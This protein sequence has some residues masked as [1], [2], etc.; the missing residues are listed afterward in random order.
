MFHK[1]S[2]SILLVALILLTLSCF[3]QELDAEGCKD[4]PLITRMPGSK[5]NSCDNKEFEEASFPLAPD[6]D[7]NSRVEKV[8]GEYHYWDY[9]TREGMSEIQ[10]FRNIEAALKRAGFSFDFEESPTTITAHKGKT[11]YLLESKGTFY[12]QTTVT[13]KQMEQEVTADADALSN[14]IMKTGHVAVYGVNFDT[15]KAT[16]LPTSEPVLS[17]I[18]KLLQ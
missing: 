7:G 9:G 18:L 17:E 8:V 12:Y 10:I 14:A 6:A 15:G 2:I 1:S 4:S 5:I 11:W 3:A 13:M 16:I